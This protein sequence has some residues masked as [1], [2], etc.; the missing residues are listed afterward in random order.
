MRIRRCGRSSGSG[1]AFTGLA[2]ARRKSEPFFEAGESTEEL[3]LVSVVGEG[4]GEGGAELM[5]PAFPAGMKL[6]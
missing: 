3:L 1:S 4:G 5:A 2:T 6:R